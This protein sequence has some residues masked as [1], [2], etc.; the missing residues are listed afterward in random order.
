M[1]TNS[2]LAVEL[3]GLSKSFDGKV[4]VR[5]LDLSIP[6]GSTYGLLGPNGAGK[7]T[8]IRMLLRIIDPDKGQ[9]RV[10]GQPLSQESLNVFGYLPEERGIYRQ[11]RVKR[12]LAFFAELKG[13][14]PRVSSPLIMQ[15]LERFELADRANSKVQELS[16]GNQQKVQLAGVMVASPE[17]L[18]LDEPTSGLDPVNVVL[19]RDILLAERAR[20][21]TIVLSTHLM[22]EAEKLCDA[23]AL[24]HRGAVVLSGAV[25]AVRASRGDTAVHLEFEGDGARLETLPGVD[26][27]TLSGHRAELRIPDGADTNALI[28]AIASR[29]R[30]RRFEVA[31]P[32]LEEIF[33]DRVGGETLATRVAEDEEAVS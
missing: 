6:R 33:L 23:V 14:K 27:V 5:D 16:K 25:A 11:M 17:L 19:V 31:A 3:I 10:L 20:G 12:L 8:S 26:A 15:W 32:S 1:T 28:G 21:A 29:V 2:G 30:I 13:M 7:T 9:V 22:G 18:L 24:I 4:A